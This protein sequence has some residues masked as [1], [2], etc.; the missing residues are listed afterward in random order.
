MSGG[1]SSSSSSSSWALLVGILYLLAG[2]LLAVTLAR[3]SRLPVLFGNN[4]VLLGEVFLTSGFLLSLG[5]DIGFSMFTLRE[6]LEGFLREVEVGLARG[7]CNVFCICVGFA[8][9][10]NLRRLT[11]IKPPLPFEKQNIYGFSEFD[12]SSN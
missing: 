8:I 11:Y 4:F 2:S 10:G 9:F 5:S 3:F 1:S 7:S 6:N 12:K